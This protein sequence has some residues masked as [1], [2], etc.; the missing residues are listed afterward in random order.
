MSKE[1]LVTCPICSR[2]GFTTRGLRQH[3]C[4]AKAAP[5]G[6]KKHSAPLTKLEWRKAVDAARAERER[7][8]R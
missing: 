6:N 5:E 1:L 8:L 3:W 2:G 7:P 4:P